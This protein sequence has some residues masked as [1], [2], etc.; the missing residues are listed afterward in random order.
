MLLM[1]GDTDF[2]EFSGGPVLC[3]GCKE[4]KHLKHFVSVREIRPISETQAR[5]F[6]TLVCGTCFLN[7]VPIQ[8]GIQ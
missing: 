3:Q 4:E 5:V 7:Q 6:M 2:P 8:G 1:R